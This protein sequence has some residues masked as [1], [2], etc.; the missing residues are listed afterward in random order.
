MHENTL[1]NLFSNTIDRLDKKIDI[2]KEQNSKIKKELTDLKESVQYDSAN[3]DEVNKKLDGIHIRVGETKL[4]R[5]IKDFV[6]KKKI[7]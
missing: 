1:L 7:S 5:I 4:D 3:V 6:S 2:L